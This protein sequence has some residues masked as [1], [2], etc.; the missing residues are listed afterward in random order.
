M[1]ILRELREIL[2]SILRFS[3]GSIS[4]VEKVKRFEGRMIRLEDLKGGNEG[5]GKTVKT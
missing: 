5:D 3:G 1:N 2:D 4:M